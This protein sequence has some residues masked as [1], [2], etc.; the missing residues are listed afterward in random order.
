MSGHE[1]R[2][3]ADTD[4]C[5]GS[6]LCAFIAPDNFDVVNGTVVV[7]EAAVPAGAAEAVREA[8]E[9]CPTRAIAIASVSERS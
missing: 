2:I 9:S 6:G 1:E 8:V 7:L 4:V 3:Q 5:M